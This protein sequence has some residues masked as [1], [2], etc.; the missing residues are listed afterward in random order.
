MTTEGRCYSRAFCA[1]GGQ[2]VV[3]EVK[4]VEKVGVRGA[5]TRAR[6]RWDGVGQVKVDAESDLALE[7]FEESCAF[8]ED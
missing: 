8:G 2:D 7:A 3:R 6:R 1:I 5:C 4:G